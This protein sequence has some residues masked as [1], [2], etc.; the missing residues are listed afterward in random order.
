MTTRTMQERLLEACQK[1][2]AMAVAPELFDDDK[3]RSILQ[4]AK[5]AMSAA[6]AEQN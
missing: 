3:R 5:E 1:L 4:E 6:K 2:F